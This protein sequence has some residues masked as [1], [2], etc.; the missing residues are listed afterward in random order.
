[1]PVQTPE[2]DFDKYDEVVLVFPIWAARIAQ[3]MK[4]YLRQVPFKG[5]KVKLIATSA[6]G[7]KGYMDGLIDSVDPS[8]K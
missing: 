8:K 7:K 6:S 5:K 4:C 2:I 1:M 3:Y